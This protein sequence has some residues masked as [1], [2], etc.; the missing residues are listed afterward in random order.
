[1]D[2]AVL[3]TYPDPK[4]NTN[5]ISIVL[6][7]V[8]ATTINANSTVTQHPTVNGTPIA[9]HMYRNPIALNLSGTFSLNGKKGIVFKNG[10]G[11][12]Q[13]IEKL[14]EEIKNTGTLCTLSK[15]AVDIN[16]TAQF[17]TREHMVLSSISWKENINTLDFNFNF[18][19]VLLATVQEYD[20]DPDDRFAPNINYAK[21]ANF[22][23]TLLDW[24]MVDR[25]VL[26]QL[27]D[28]ELIAK[29]FLDL[30]G[31]LSVAACVAIVGASVATAVIAGMVS[32]LIAISATG[33]GAIVAGVV[34]AVLAVVAGI[35]ALFKWIKKQAYRIK[36]FVYYKNAK[37][38]DK[39]VKR[40]IEFY[41][42]IHDKIR[43]L[44]GVIKCYTINENVPQETILSIGGNYYVFDFESNNLNDGSSYAYKLVVT[45]IEDNVQCNA[46]TNYAITSFMDGTPDNKLFSANGNYVYLVYSPSGVTSGREAENRRIQDANENLGVGVE[47]QEL[48]DTATA[49]DRNDL[50]NY[51][52]CTSAMN[53]QDFTEALKK[54]IVEAIKY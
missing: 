54:I 17:M 31:S 47:K 20:V 39:E 19:E 11:S 52:I 18:Q 50:R 48:I 41:N 40:F 42:S 13:K 30:L 23:D 46:N 51:I 29:E 45:D 15:I 22:S 7:T 5:I 9:D 4:D 8:E 28:F 27:W 43:A 44:D 12:L 25:M 53:P 36:A 16:N 35:V 2:Y 49:D 37:K 14:F 21:A 10:H 38:R 32:G 34:V 6:D 26:K 3:L 33:I 1:M 24:D